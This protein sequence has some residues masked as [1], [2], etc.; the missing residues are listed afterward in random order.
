MNQAAC[1]HG[2]TKMSTPLDVNAVLFDLFDFVTFSPLTI[3]VCEDA[4]VTHKVCI[5]Q[6]R[7]K[8]HAL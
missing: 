3:C 2:A 6:K 8:K 4:N 5:V 7:K 1:R